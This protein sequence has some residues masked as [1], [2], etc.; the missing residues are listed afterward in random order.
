MLAGTTFHSGKKMTD[1]QIHEGPVLDLEGW[2]ALLRS[3]CCGYNVQ[4]GDSKFFVGTLRPRSVSGLEAVD[5]SCNAYRVDRTLTDTRRDD[6]DHFALFFSTSGRLTL[7]Q[8]DR[9]TPVMVGH[10]ALVDVARPLSWIM[11]STLIQGVALM[12]PR[13]TVISQLGLEPEGNVQ[14]RN[15]TSAAHL[16]SRLVLDAPEECDDSCAS[17]ERYMQLAICD[18]L[19]AMLASSDLLTYSSQKEKLFRRVS[20]IVKNNFTDPGIRPRDIANEAGISLRYL[21]KLFTARGTT[22]G[23]F[24]QSLRLD[25]AARLVQSMRLTKSGQPLSDIAYASGF[26]DYTHFARTFRRK[27][28]HAPS[29]SRLA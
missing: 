22:C 11:D 8:N 24:I 2:Q 17:A 3:H 1:S 29:D 9:S 14:W 16:L 4:R 15:D 12:L 13:Q 21:Q 10:C 23:G 7:I 5:L 6:I 27:F 26:Q 18:L 20:D 19:G 28:G 25:H